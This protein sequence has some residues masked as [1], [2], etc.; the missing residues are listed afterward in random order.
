MDL[1][2]QYGIYNLYIYIDIEIDHNIY[3]YAI[4]I[5]NVFSIVDTIYCEYI[6][7]SVTYIHTMYSI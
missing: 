2:T 6:V 1:H 3:I 5:Q 7:D 4:C